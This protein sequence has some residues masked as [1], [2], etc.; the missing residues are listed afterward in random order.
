MIRGRT[1]L[2][3]LCAV[4]VLA[5]CG[6]KGALSRPVPEVATDAGTGVDG[7]AL[8]SPTTEAPAEDEA[9]K[10]GAEIPQPSAPDS[11]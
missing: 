5:S 11:P 6:R 9:L 7:T 10:R 1:I 2:L 4:A 3:G 8:D